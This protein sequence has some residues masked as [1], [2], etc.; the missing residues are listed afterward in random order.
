[1]GREKD[2]LDNQD[3][4]EVTKNEVTEASSP[5]NCAGEDIKDRYDMDCATGEYI[6]DLSDRYI[7]LFEF[8]H[9]VK[10]YRFSKSDCGG[11]R[12]EVSD[13]VN[14]SVVVD[15]VK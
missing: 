14:V 6:N 10:F 8:R 9:F 13:G 15:V 3:V 1:M 7:K 4:R 5:E 11:N 2:L 12:K